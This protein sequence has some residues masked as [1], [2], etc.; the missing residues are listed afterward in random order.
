MSAPAKIPACRF[1]SARR[2]RLSCRTASRRA[3]RP[4]SDASATFVPVR[5]GEPGRRCLCFVSRFPARHPQGDSVP[6]LL[7]RS[8]EKRPLS[9]FAVARPNVSSRLCCRV[10]ECLCRVGFLLS[11]DTGKSAG[12]ERRRCEAKRRSEL[13]PS[14]VLFAFRATNRLIRLFC[15]PC[16]PIK[17]RT[18]PRS[19][20]SLRVRCVRFFP[21]RRVRGL[22]VPRSFGSRRRLEWR[23]KIGRSDP[24][25]PAPD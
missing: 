6:Y 19:G 9:V 3:R 20:K 12:C 1:P 18:S 25:D 21:R 11:D 14:V 8:D 16:F 24:S 13:P 15:F 17:L 22:R 10:L 5:N 23:K 2:R 4:A 7:L